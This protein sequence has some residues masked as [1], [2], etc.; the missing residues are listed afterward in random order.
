MTKGVDFNFSTFR[1]P[2]KEWVLN[3]VV[4]FVN[5][6]VQGNFHLVLLKGR[7]MAE[8]CDLTGIFTIFGLWD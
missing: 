4:V 3:F 6:C 7:R 8:L 1:G 2:T 5:L